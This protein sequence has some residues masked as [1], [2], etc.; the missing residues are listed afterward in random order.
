MAPPV[1]L[2]NVDLNLLVALD[3]LLAERSVTIAGRRVHLS[4]SAMS[5]V[6]ARL[7]QMFNDELLIGGRGGMTL[8]PLAEQLVEPVGQIL[9]QVEHTL[10][11]TIR[12]DPASSSRRFTIAASDYVVVVL[13]AAALREIHRQAPGVSVI[14]VPLRDRM[15][16]L[17]NPAIDLV[18]LPRAHVP[19]GRS[20]VPLFTDV[21]TAIV[22][23]NHPNV[24]SALSVDD[25]RSLGHV[26]VTFASDR[27]VS[28]DQVAA[29]EAGLAPRIAV[30]AP[31]Y[32]AL[33][34]L[35]VGTTHVATI[36]RRLATHL[37]AMYPL[38]EV[39]LPIELPP[40]EE[41]MIWHP[42]FERDMGHEWCRG[43]LTDVAASF[44]S[45]LAGINPRLS[46]RR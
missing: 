31:S 43:V 15:E 22:A 41:V 16:K 32:L 8:T 20:S 5:G 14:I 24:G 40:L 37:A 34:G 36:Q 6:L 7:R 35:V 45:P 27:A 25:Y 28:D 9:R 19:P 13:L 26:V 17:E 21:F 2:S 12:F 38:K 46:P 42:R 30:V 29:A 23:A 39:S 33:P 1:D 18:I 11:T 3:A 10:S 4:Q 44:V